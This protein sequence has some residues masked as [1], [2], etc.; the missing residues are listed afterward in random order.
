MSQTYLEITYRAGKPFAA[1]V[2]LPRQPADRSAR[3]ERRGRFLI[4]FTETGR[5]IGIE[6]PSLT[7]VDPM[8]VNQLL[9]DLRE[10]ELLP[11]DLAP[12]TAA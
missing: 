5:P 3:T 6:I 7:G 10:T 4:D 11:A 12:L 1:Y 2:Y 8:A 9:A